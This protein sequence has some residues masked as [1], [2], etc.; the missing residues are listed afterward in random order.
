[1]GDYINFGENPSITRVTNANE[2]DSDAVRKFN[3]DTKTL[4]WDLKND[5]TASK[6]GD[7]NVYTLNY[8]ITLDNLVENFQAKKPYSTNGKQS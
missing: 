4:I 5:V 1:M 7:W 8:S 2:A 6:E 3:T